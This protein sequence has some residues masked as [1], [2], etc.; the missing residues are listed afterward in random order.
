MRI[1]SGTYADDKT[2]F[3]WRQTMSTIART[4]LAFTLPY[5]VAYYSIIGAW[6]G[7]QL[8]MLWMRAT[9]WFWQ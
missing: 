9:T 6:R 1:M 8:L 3:P 5:F 4:T 2:A 7:V